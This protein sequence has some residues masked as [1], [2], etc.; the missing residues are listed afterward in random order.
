MRREGRFVQ[1]AW[2]KGRWSSE[3]LYAMLEDEWP[4]ASRS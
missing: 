4:R 3:Y 1:N 2:F